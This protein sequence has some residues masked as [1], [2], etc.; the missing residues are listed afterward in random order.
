MKK[1]TETELIDYLHKHTNVYE[2]RQRAYD[3]YATMNFNNLTRK[4][5]EELV[6][7]Y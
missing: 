3:W 5:L 2:I 7:L 4:E 1:P 6:S